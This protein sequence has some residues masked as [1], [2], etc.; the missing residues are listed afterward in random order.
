MTRFEQQEVARREHLALLAERHAGGE[1]LLA[2][3]EPPR[4]DEP[5]VVVHEG[6]A[7]LLVAPGVEADRQ[8][9][10]HR[11]HP[12]LVERH[13]RAGPGVEH[14]AEHV[15]QVELLRE[16]RGAVA[17]LDGLRVR[18]VVPLHRREVLHGARECGRRPEGLEHGE[19]PVD[20]LPCLGPAGQPR[21]GAGVHAQRVALVQWVAQALP[22]ADRLGPPV[23]RL[24]PLVDQPQ[25]GGQVVEHLGAA[26]WVEAEAGRGRE[27]PVEVLHGLPVRGERGGASG[28]RP[29]VLHHGRRCRPRRRRG[30]RAGSRHRRHARAARRGG[31]G[32]GWCAVA[33]ARHPRPTGGR[34]RAGTAASARR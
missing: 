11:R 5:A 17:R 6:P 2:V 28:G 13:H 1:D 15:G 16:G 31:A 33:R 20:G 25:L 21:Q 14:V 4:V 34:S 18:P 22:E 10:P 30:R 24:L 27:G 23:L 19:R 29:R 7:H 26:A 3:V 9:A 12:V 8:G 32:G